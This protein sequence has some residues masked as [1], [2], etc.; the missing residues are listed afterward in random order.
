[1][2][3]LGTD[4]R[5]ARRKRAAALYAGGS[6]MREIADELK[7]SIATVFKYLDE[8]EIPRDRSA[9]AAAGARRRAAPL[10][11]KILANAGGRCGSPGCSDPDCKV[12]PGQC[13]RPGCTER[14]TIASQ[15]WEA[16]RRVAG[17]SM[18]YCSRRCRGLASKD[19][20]GA[21]A[22][23]RLANAGGCGSPG[24]SDPDCKVP[25]GQCHRPDSRNRRR[26][27]LKPRQKWAGSKGTR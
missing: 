20:L 11:E 27:R 10:R 12:P 7:V 3:P 23:E 4:E 24:C 14:A 22:L 2:N 21:A 13:H 17:H 5:S 1:M 15:T 25:P 16:Q 26:S 18:M 9:A 8:L 19:E 6:T